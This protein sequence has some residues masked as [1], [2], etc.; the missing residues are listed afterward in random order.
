[1]H[2]E[3]SDNL[4]DPTLRRA[5]QALHRPSEKRAVWAEL[6]GGP[7]LNPALS[8]GRDLLDQAD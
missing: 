7:G 4:Q 6:D 1:V 3:V 5:A 2:G 8:L